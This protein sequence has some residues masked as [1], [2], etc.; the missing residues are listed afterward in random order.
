MDEAVNLEML[1]I[2]DLGQK[3]FFGKIEIFHVFPDPL[4]NRPGDG[5]AEHRVGDNA[6]GTLIVEIKKIVVTEGGGIVHGFPPGDLFPVFFKQG[7]DII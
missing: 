4:G 1:R 2:V 5:N 3:D 6:F 7:P